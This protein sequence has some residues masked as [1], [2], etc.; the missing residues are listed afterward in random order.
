MKKKTESIK[1]VL[2]TILKS[3]ESSFKDEGHRIW[4]IWDDAVGPELARRVQPHK[5][6][7]GKLTVAVEGSAWLQQIVFL[8]PKIIETVNARLENPAIKTLKGI[9][10][11]V[12]PKSTEVVS[13]PVFRDTPLTVLELEEIEELLRPIKDGDIK[14]AARKALEAARLRITDDRDR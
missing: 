3:L 10:A 6:K 11:E 12:K 9:A 2:P 14:N 1:G 7:N 5:F 4:E 8:A 13:P